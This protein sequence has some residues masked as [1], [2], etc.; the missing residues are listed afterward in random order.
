MGLVKF[1]LLYIHSRWDTGRQTRFLALLIGFAD[2]CLFWR[3]VWRPSTLGRQLF[4]IL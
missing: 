2:F 3:P 1:G 4:F